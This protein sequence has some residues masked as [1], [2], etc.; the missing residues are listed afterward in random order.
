[1]VDRRRRMLPTLVLRFPP[2]SS[3]CTRCGFGRGVRV[4]RFCCGTPAVN[5]ISS[6]KVSRSDANLRRACS[7]S[8]S[9]RPEPPTCMP[10]IVVL[11]RLL[12]D[13]LDSGPMIV[14]TELRLSEL[15][16]ADLRLRPSTLDRPSCDF[17]RIS[18]VSRARS[19][20]MVSSTSTGGEARPLGWDR[21]S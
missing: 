13:C 2:P 10:L 19:S 15:K 18:S 12:A 3:C 6:K 9:L 7:K 17:G 14:P 4:G 20:S 8:T 21:S 11:L 16:R 5:C 1:M